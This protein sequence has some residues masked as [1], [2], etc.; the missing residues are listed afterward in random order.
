MVNNRKYRS[1]N[2]LKCAPARAEHAVM[3]TIEA[4]VH[5]DFMDVAWVRSY[6]STR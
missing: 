2:V 3:T 1:V 4:A 5:V 6:L